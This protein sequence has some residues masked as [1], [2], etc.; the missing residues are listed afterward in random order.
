MQTI[1]ILLLA[2]VL[3]EGGRGKIVNVLIA[4]VSIQII[5]SGVNM[6]PQL[7]TY[8]SNLI[9]ATL[10]LIVLMATTRL[11]NVTD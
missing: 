4:I 3:P 7:N 9:S 8:Y 10:L 6:F 11:L 2:G 5:S 1:L